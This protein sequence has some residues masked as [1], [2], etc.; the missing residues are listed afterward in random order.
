MK[1]YLL[2]SVALLSAARVVSAKVRIMLSLSFGARRVFVVIRYGASSVWILFVA[3]AIVT[4]M[5]VYMI[6][7]YRDEMSV[8]LTAGMHAHIYYTL[9]SHLSS[10]SHTKVH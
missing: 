6:T 2:A 9:E 8:C 4:L 10:S 1:L 5:Y 7:R 3:I